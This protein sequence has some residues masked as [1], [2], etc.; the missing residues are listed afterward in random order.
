MKTI[1]VF[2]ATRE[3][4]TRRVASYVSQKLR[5]L[6]HEVEVVDVAH[7]DGVRIEHYDGVILAA[8]VHMWRHPPEMRHFVRKH[9]LSL[10]R[11]PTAFLSVSM[12]EAAWE[13]SESRADQQVRARLDAHWLMDRFFASTHWHPDIAEPVAGALMY[14]QYSPLVKLLMQQIARASGGATDTQR[15]HEYTDWAQLD[16]FTKR[17]SSLLAGVAVR[18]VEVA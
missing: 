1:G 8:S 4:Q 17:F 5:D 6:G 15:D 9:R 7:P 12:C 11:V 18:R 2:Y 10:A 13:R 14:T 3:G 16:G